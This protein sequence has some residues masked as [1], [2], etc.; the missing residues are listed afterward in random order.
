MIFVIFK[1]HTFNKDKEVKKEN[2]LSQKAI[3]KDVLSS[4]TEMF[5]FYKKNPSEKGLTI[6]IMKT[7][8]LVANSK[9]LSAAFAKST[10]E[11]KSH[12][13][14]D[15]VENKKAWLENKSKYEQAKRNAANQPPIHIPYSL[16][17][18]FISKSRYHYVTSTE[19]ARDCIKKA[20]IMFK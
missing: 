2:A 8:K 5:N 3:K 7:A 13:Y 1:N 20:K 4:L 14:N 6:E 17:H 10:Y 11:R 15:F 18:K 19:N 9:S 16:S 12:V